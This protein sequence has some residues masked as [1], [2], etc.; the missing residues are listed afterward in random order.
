MVMLS[1]VILRNAVQQGSRLVKH[2]QWRPQ[3]VLSVSSLHF[4]SSSSASNKVG[5]VAN[6]TKTKQN[7]KISSDGKQK[8]RN[9]EQNKKISA[10]GKKAEQ[11]KKGPGSGKDLKH[12]Q[13]MPPKLTRLV[14]DCKDGA[15]PSL[16]NI[17]ILTSRC[18]QAGVDMDQV[19][20]FFIRHFR[21]ASKSD[22]KSGANHNRE[23]NFFSKHL[24]EKYQIDNSVLTRYLTSYLLPNIYQK[25]DK[26]KL[27]IKRA[28]YC[29]AMMRL[30]Y[31][32]GDMPTMTEENIKIVETFI[33]TSNIKDETLQTILKL[34]VAK[35][36]DY[37]VTEEDREVLINF[38]C[39]KR[40]VVAGETEGSGA[41]M[42]SLLT[43]ADSLKMISTLVSSPVSLYDRTRLLGRTSQLCWEQGNFSLA[44]DT[45][46]TSTEQYLAGLLSEDQKDQEKLL[47]AALD[48][49]DVRHSIASTAATENMM[50]AMVYL[51]SGAEMV[52][53]KWPQSGL[54]LLPSYILL[55]SVNN[56]N[57][58]AASLIKEKMEARIVERL[59][60]SKFE[61][62]F[63][64]AGMTRETKLFF[65]KDYLQ[66]LLFD[67]SPLETQSTPEI[68]T[69]TQQ[70]KE[71]IPAIKIDA[72]LAVDML[73]ISVLELA[74]EKKNAEMTDAIL[75][76][77]SKSGLLPSSQALETV[78]KTLQDSS[79]LYSLTSL[80]R[81]VPPERSERE[82]IYEAIASLKLRELNSRWEEDKVKAWVGLVQLYRK[83]W[84]DQTEG[85]IPVETRQAAVRKCCNYARLFIEEA[86]QS[87]AS[88]KL[89]KPMQL[90]CSKVAT[91]F[92]D[93][94]LLTM[95]W[96]ALFFSVEMDHNQLSD[97]ILDNVPA[98]LDQIN[99]DSVLQRCER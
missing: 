16:T 70:I 55:L 21:K 12:I 29:M 39:D 76:E 7:K 26:V 97:L 73:D 58:E 50:P 75:L 81:L 57:T 74:S 48:I 13:S 1:R 64:V 31:I 91:D 32:L 3:P 69:E 49:V 98:L 71:E 90:G 52:A 44:L 28:E 22:E 11:T 19:E 35:R 96:E 89:M 9:P 43:L 83:I 5:Q 25:V 24:L 23:Y 41:K 87:P 33:L 45:L 6:N 84:T 67:S 78:I 51:V 37:Q 68:I 54:G 61:R 79:D 62:C 36:N 86:I 72:A 34:A 30:A 17:S 10:D 18:Q 85:E 63:L 8:N 95:Y 42:P 66:R 46:T 27:P 14:T 20:D 92:A 77:H 94:S 38:V 2:S 93:L 40:I 53:A 99:I 82:R 59:R 88:D 65:I 56:V 60:S 4:Y 15:W 80:R 47:S